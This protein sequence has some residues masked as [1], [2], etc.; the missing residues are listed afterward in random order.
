MNEESKQRGKSII[1]DNCD[2]PL[3]LKGK[4]YKAM[5]QHAIIYK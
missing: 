2:D 5:A 3:R 4:L 1:L